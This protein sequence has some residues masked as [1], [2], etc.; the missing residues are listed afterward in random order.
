MI[1]SGGQVT[2]LGNTLSRVVHIDEVNARI[3]KASA[4]FGRLCGSIW[5]Q[6]GI[7]IKLKV[8]RSVVLPALLYACET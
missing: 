1:A 8:Y 7:D 5:D 2:Y 3:A 4:A 6:S